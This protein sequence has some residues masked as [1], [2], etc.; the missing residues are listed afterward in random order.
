MLNCC[1][2][3]E[4]DNKMSTPILTMR[5]TGDTYADMD[6]MLA[7]HKMLTET[8]VNYNYSQV[9]DGLIIFR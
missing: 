6:L 1:Y 2:N 4:R 8:G 3:N 9:I 7:I 5:S